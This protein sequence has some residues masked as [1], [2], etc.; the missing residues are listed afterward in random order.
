MFYVYYPPSCPPPH[1]H[2]T[3]LKSHN[4]SS[5]N[6]DSHLNFTLPI[7]SYL[8]EGPTFLFHRYLKLSM[9]QTFTIFSSK[10]FPQTCNLLV[11]FFFYFTSVTSN[12]HRAQARTLAIILKTSF[13]VQPPI[14]P[15]G[16]LESISCLFH[17]HCHHTS[18][19]RHCL[20]LCQGHIL[21]SRC[22]LAYIY[23]IF[24]W[25]DRMLLFKNMDNLV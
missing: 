17:L 3:Y 23:P 1:H 24:H 6:P 14:P 25:I 2:H 22:T 11:F 10:Q 20:Y 19:W 21:K 15:H 5:F 16:Y 13:S 12:H 8:P 7:C 18:S 4:F 9:S